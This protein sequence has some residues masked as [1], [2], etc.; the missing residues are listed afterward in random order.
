MPRR[1]SPQW[2]KPFS[3]WWWGGVGPK[4]KAHS[5]DYAKQEVS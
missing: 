3:Y 4:R 1:L 5:L 2:F